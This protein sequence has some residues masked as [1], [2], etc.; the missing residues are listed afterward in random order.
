[1][2]VSASSWLV[3][4]LAIF[5]ANLPFLNERCLAVLTLPRWPAKPFWCRL[6]EL[7]AAYFIV[8]GLAY[9][10]ESHAGN[11]FSQ[12]WEF[13]AIT[14]CLFIVLAFPGFVYRYLKKRHG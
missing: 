1:M 6:L 7:V 12:G 5:A 3:I 14:A 11:R 10:L 8:G 13:Y 9:L 4:F 2:D